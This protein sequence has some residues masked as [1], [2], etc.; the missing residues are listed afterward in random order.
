MNKSENRNYYA[1]RSEHGYVMALN[2]DESLQVGGSLIKSMSSDRAY[3]RGLYDFITE[4]TD[5]DVV[6]EMVTLITE[7]IE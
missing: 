7:E 3:V 6:L 1:I 5:H 2:L 4:E